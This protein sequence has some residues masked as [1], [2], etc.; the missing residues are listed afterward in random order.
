MIFGLNPITIL[1]SGFAGS[2]LSMV[3]GAVLDKLDVDVEAAV[4]IN[5]IE[6]FEKQLEE[7]RNQYQAIVQ[8]G[9]SKGNFEMIQR[10]NMSV[11]RNFSRL[12]RAYIFYGYELK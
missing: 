2:F 5:V 1:L 6:A 8:I 9:M 10:A 7:I 12:E 3:A 4:N 11:R